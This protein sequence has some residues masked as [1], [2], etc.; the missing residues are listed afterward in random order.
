MLYTYVMTNDTG[1]APHVDQSLRP[2]WTLA[3]C[4]PTIRRVAQRSDWILVVGGKTLAKRCGHDVN[5]RAIYLAKVSEKLDYDQYYSDPRFRERPDYKRPDNIYHHVGR[6][7]RQDKNDYHP[8]VKHKN[9]DLRGKSVLVSDWFVSFG[10]NGPHVPVELLKEGPG[11]RKLDLAKEP[12]A[13]NFMQRLEI[14]N[15]FR[16]RK[17]VE[18]LLS[19][20]KP[21]RYYKCT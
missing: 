19:D 13:A 8:T 10:S 17:F 9:H 1:F 18:P 4:K 21:M 20:K 3:T 2:Y 11:H 16:F 6:T 7:M 14:R 5:H 12:M 15:K